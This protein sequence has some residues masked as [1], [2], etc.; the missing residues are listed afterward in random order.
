V[1]TAVIER[2][3]GAF[4]V[5]S[6]VLS[7]L[8]AGRPILLAAPGANLVAK[9]VTTIGAGS[10]ADPDDQN[11]W[12]A[13]AANLIAEPA[14]RARM[15]AAGRAYAEANFDLDRVADRFEAIFTA[16]MSNAPRAQAG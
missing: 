8:C 11:A 7:Y 15:G 2:D 6:K 16:A 12:L 5:P 1:L 4:S 3:A 13:A 9:T 10:V 14:L